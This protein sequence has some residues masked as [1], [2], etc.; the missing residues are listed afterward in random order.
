MSTILLVN[1]N[2]RIP[3]GDLPAIEPPVWLSL[4]ASHLM[5]DKYSVSILDAEAEGLTVE[6]TV[7]RVEACNTRDVVLVVMGNSPSVSST[8][9][10]V[11]TEKILKQLN[12]DRVW[13]T[14][15]HP[16]A[17]GHE[18]LW[19]WKPTKCLPIHW[20]LLPM[21]LYRAHNWHCLD[22]SPRSP[23]ASIYTSLGCP[24]NCFYCNIH[25]LYQSRE[26]LYRNYRNVVYE[27]ERLAGDYGVRNIKI[28][29]ELFA[30]SLKR[31]SEIFTHLQHNDLNIWAYARVNT[32]TEPMLEVMKEAGVTWLAYGFES[33]SSEV[34]NRANKSFTDKQVTD[35]IDM[36][37][38]HGINIIANIMFGLPG[39]TEASAMETI[40]WVKECNFEFVNFSVAL[41]YPG[42]KWYEDNKPNMKWSDYDQHQPN[43]NSWF[44]FRDTAFEEYFI[45]KEYQ[46]MI[47]EKFGER[48]L[49]MIQSMVGGQYAKLGKAKD[50]SLHS[51]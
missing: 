49:S 44:A 23:Y 38:K 45:G 11:V 19:N 51:S 9:K 15:L 18:K 7:R 16:M 22:G 42:S 31:V 28:W 46:K 13:V 48:G 32:V 4:M 40:K 17:V 39:E 50:I 34:R 47:K 21:E 6:D 33:K 29:D 41:P 8:P 20:E 2:N 24:F 25:A 30:S 43:K 27:I 26:V 36:T 35:V 10:M 1:P 37:R 3:L 12:R 5:E 14:G